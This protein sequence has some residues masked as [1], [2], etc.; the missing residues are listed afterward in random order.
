M[1]PLHVKYL[2]KL[3]HLDARVGPKVS[4]AV[5]STYNTP[6]GDTL[7][8]SHSTSQSAWVSGGRI[9]VIGCHSVILRPDSVR[10]VRPPMTRIPS[11]KPEHDSSHIGKDFGTVDIGAEEAICEMFRV[12]EEKKARR[13]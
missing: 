7:Y 8:F 6:S 1:G 4:S 3:A 13:L 10:R 2:F 5:L 12:G 11:T 9:P